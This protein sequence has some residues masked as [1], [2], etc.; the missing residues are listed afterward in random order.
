M[1]PMKVLSVA[2]VLGSFLTLSRAAPVNS[3]GL[4]RS[5]G[6]C[7][8]ERAHS[9]HNIGAFVP[10]CDHNGN[11]LPQQCWASTGYCWC[12]NVITGEEI[13]NTKTPPGTMPVSCGSEFY[14]PNSW[15]LFGEQCFI[16]INSMKS[17]AEAEG[18]CLFEGANLASVHSPMENHFIQAL[19]R[20]DTY[21]FPQ[22]WIGGYDAIYLLPPESLL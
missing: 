4:M 18:Y 20:G 1:T 11:F 14:C 12:V 17:W 2:L 6:L 15:T 19:T 10:Q 3:T 5:S 8:Y 7:A 9:P 16:F 21:D 22:T 13:P